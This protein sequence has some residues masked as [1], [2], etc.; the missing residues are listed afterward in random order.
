ME[1]PNN[2]YFFTGAADKQDIA[3][4]FIVVLEWNNLTTQQ[5]GVRHVIFD[6]LGALSLCAYCT[7]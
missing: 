1:L 2:A 5:V 3:V 7:G 4:T 6:L